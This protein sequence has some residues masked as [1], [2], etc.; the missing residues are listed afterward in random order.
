MT[1]DLP[2]LHWE[3]RAPGACQCASSSNRLSS[4]D[5]VCGGAAAISSTLGEVQAG[6]HPSRADKLKSSTNAL[7]PP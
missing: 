1:T 7:P 2:T 5:P 6:G 3:E 4:T